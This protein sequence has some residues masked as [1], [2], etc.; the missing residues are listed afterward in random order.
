MNDLLCHLLW[1]CNTLLS[2]FAELLLQDQ[3]YTSLTYRVFLIYPNKIWCLLRKFPNHNLIQV[4]IGAP[5]AVEEKESE[6]VT[7]VRDHKT[8]GGQAAVS[9]QQRQRRTSWKE[10][11]SR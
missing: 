9:P 2:C 8:T 7:G 5:I 4:K 1:M 3:F 6:K 10:V 11:I